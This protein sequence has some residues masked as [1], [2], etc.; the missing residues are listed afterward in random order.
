MTQ[1]CTTIE[2]SKRLLDLGIKRETADMFW[3]LGSSLPEVCCVGDNMQAD[4]P[5]WSLGALLRLIPETIEHRYVFHLAHFGAYY[6]DY[7]NEVKYGCEG[8][9]VFKNCITLI[10]DLVKSRCINGEII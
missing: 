7:D 9:D 1:I 4:Y 3:P 5:S 10:E 8:V 6:C 2:Q